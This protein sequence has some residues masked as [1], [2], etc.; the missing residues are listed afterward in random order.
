[1]LTSTAAL[2][3][4]GYQNGQRTSADATE[5]DIEFKNSHVA[6]HTAYNV[7]QRA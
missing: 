5:I 2:P 7:Y 3:T 6:M 1:M 4:S